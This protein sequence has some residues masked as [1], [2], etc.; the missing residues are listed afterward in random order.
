MRKRYNVSIEFQRLKQVSSTTSRHA[1][2]H[3]Y[4]PKL[5]RKRES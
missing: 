5:D 4:K 3:E 2:M 1:D